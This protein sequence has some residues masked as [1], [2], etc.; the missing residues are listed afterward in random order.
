MIFSNACSLLM[1]IYILIPYFQWS[2]LD[3]NTKPKWGTL[4]ELSK[5]QLIWFKLAC[6]FCVLHKSQPQVFYSHH[7]WPH[8]QIMINPFIIYENALMNC[9][10]KDKTID[11][12]YFLLQN[13]NQR[14]ITT[15]KKVN[16]SIAS[17][18]HII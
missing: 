12:H 4:I 17:K 1:S 7:E 5:L 9:L 6:F 15:S 16:T 14:Q 8:T 3:S 2:Q 18:L 10:V 11:L 13:S